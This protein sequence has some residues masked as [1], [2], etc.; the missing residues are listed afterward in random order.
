MPKKR[1]AYAQIYELLKIKEKTRQETEKE[2][3]EKKKQ[4][5]Q[6]QIKEEITKLNEWEEIKQKCTELY[7]TNKEMINPTEFFTNLET[8]IQLTK[9]SNQKESIYI[10][11][12][13]DYK[14]KYKDKLV[15]FDENKGQ[16]KALNEKKRKIEEIYKNTAEQ[17]QEEISIWTKTQPKHTRLKIKGFKTGKEQ[18]TTTGSKCKIRAYHK[19]I[20]C[21]EFKE[22]YM[23][24]EQTIK[25]MQR[26]E[27]TK[28]LQ[29]KVFGALKQPNWYEKLILAVM[30]STKK[31][32]NYPLHL[33][34]MDIDNTLNGEKGQGSMGKTMLNERLNKISGT[35]EDIFD[36]TTSTLK[37]A[38]ISNAIRKKEDGTYLLRRN[39]LAFL[40]EWGHDL[41]EF[42]KT[43]K[44][45]EKYGTGLTTLWSHGIRQSESGIK[46]KELIKP[47]FK[48]I[49]TGNAPEGIFSLQGL[50]NLVHPPFLQRNLLYLMSKEH[51]DF[52]NE[53]RAKTITELNKQGHLEFDWNIKELLETGYRTQI[54]IE[55]MINEANEIHKNI[56]KETKELSYKLDTVTKNSFENRG[57]HHILCLIDGLTKLNNFNDFKKQIKSLEEN[58]EYQEIKIKTTEKDFKE[59]EEIMR[60]II[61]SWEEE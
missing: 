60:K 12:S 33:I 11:Q 21:K 37:G 48:A 18:E 24:K 59:T 55:N 31:I 46:N 54:P 36:F 41:T 8:E 6:E 9:I 49:T 40:D 13:T 3:I 51:R 47:Q 57:L 20:Y 35:N 44:S 38:T 2:L 27:N 61:K 10:M 32:E 14:G 53:R 1:R 25:E 30:L 56:L 4:I 45:N 58:K 52:I 23:K 15:F 19:I 34:I 17:D 29:E 50:T 22:I 39:H 7:N 5:K 26:F 42:I 16:I 43:R 28:E